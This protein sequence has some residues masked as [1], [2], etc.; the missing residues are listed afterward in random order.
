[1]IERYGVL[2]GRIRQELGD[3]ERV[4]KRAERAAAAADEDSPYPDLLL[5]SAALSLHDAYS[6]IERLLEQIA[7]TVDRGVPSTHDWHRELLR[8]MTIEITGLRPP[9][10]SQGVAA[11]LDQYRRFRH[12]VRNV[13]AFDLE[14]EP[15]QR[16]TTSLRGIFVQVCA[17]LLAFADFLDTV[18]RD[19]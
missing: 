5:D 8:Q 14:P 6:G 17:E 9:V 16:L 10:L 18:A 1:V 4:V 11:A 3:I 12:V 2:A 7:S 13:Y 19:E 15:V